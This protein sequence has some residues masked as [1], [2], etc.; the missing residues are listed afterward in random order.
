MLINDYLFINDNILIDRDHLHCM[1]T[2]T[3]LLLC[4]QLFIKNKV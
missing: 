2:C 1:F 4:K 3:S